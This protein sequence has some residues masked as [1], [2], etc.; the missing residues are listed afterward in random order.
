LTALK[1]RNA[2][3]PS[4]AGHKYDQEGAK[5]MKKRIHAIAL[6]VA[7]AWTVSASSQGVPPVDVTLVGREIRLSRDPVEVQR[8]QGAVVIRWQLPPGVDYRF[9]PTGI[10]VNGER[11]S[12]GL[13]PQDQLPASCFSGGPAHVTCPNRNTKRGEYKYTI[14]LRDRNQ[15]L[16]ERDP[17]IVNR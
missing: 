16:I 1:V 12:T 9:D 8:K 10:V 13:R 6:L 5:K 7:L 15:N 2:G 3:V 11:T 4:H 14:R 17:I